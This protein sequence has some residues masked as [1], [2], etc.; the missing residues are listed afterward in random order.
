MTS[1]IEITN[2]RIVDF[3]S[4]H[5]SMNIE[6]V[7][8]WMIDLFE[9]M[10]NQ[11]ENNNKTFQE[12]S[13]NLQKQSSKLEELTN[14]FKSKEEMNQLFVQN[15]DTKMLNVNKTLNILKDDISSHVVSKF[16][17]LKKEYLDHM[18]HV[19]ENTSHV[20]R[21]KLTETI[22]KC[23]G[24]ISEKIENVF[25]KGNQGELTK[26]FK[27]MQ[28][29]L[30]PML[31]TINA[32]I[33]SSCE[34]VNKI[35]VKQDGIVNMYKGSKT[36]GNL[37]E[38]KLKRLLCFIYP[39]A[40][41]NETS[42]EKK[43]CDIQLMRKN[44][45]VVLFENKDYTTSVD[46]DEVKKFIRDIDVMKCHGIF[47]SQ[48]S[49]VTGKDNFQIDFH[50]G[51]VLIY[52]HFGNYDE[53]KVKTAVNIIDHLSIKLDELDDDTQEGNLISDE[54]MEE[55]NTECR[56]FIEQKDAM[57]LTCGDFNTKIKSQINMMEFKTLKRFLSTKYATEK[58]L[59][60]YCEACDLNCKNLRA[61]KAH[62][63]GAKCKANQSDEKNETS[64]QNMV[65]KVNT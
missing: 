26:Y 30:A 14:S 50:N 3:Y 38:Q 51:F 35:D 55:I 60:Y 53:D 41:I 57:L 65:I 27:N 32:N 1:R 20:S 12:I 45:P 43:S 54:Q 7:N 31:N 5:K 61:L 25:Q 2:P 10:G 11:P 52:I 19:L 17:T 40:D 29:S 37:G 33:A 9:K 23:N 15:M 22:D 39:G 6:S 36:R 13:F 59:E 42:T 28:D 44:K 63:R 8:L 64:E 18:T 24:V 58:N 46:K 62:K 16:A 21:E 4:K 56:F 34:I 48:D 47:I 49:P